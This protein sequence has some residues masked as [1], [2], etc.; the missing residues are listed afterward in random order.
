MSALWTSTIPVIST[1]H[2][3]EETYDYLITLPINTTKEL[4]APYLY[5]LFLYI[6]DDYKSDRPDLQA[7]AAWA[8]QHDYMCVRLDRDGDRVDEL[9]YYEW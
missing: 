1:G 4:V 9:P 3:T 8:A 6:G 2:I 7:L 5:G